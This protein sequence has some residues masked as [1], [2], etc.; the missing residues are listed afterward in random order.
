MNFKNEFDGRGKKYRQQ[1]P[2]DLGHFLSADAG[3]DHVIGE[4]SISLF[5]M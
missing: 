2:E 3:L 5:K 4:C 1:T